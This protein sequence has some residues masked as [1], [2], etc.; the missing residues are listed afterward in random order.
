MYLFTSELNI[1]SYAKKKKDQ[2][3]PAKMFW[4]KK[5]KTVFLFITKN[6]MYFIDMLNTGI[7]LYYIILYYYK[8]II[9]KRI[10]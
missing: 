6:N 1:F 2:H 7:M 8:H 10:T 3:C 4:L 9:K 5:Y